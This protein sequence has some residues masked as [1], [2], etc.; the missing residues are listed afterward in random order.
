MNSEPFADAA[1][2][3]RVL[4]DN[5]AGAHRRAARSLFRSLAD[6]PLRPCRLTSS[7]SRLS[8]RAIERPSAW[9][10]PLGASFKAMM[11]FDNLDVVVLT[12]HLGGFSEQGDENVNA[13]AGVGREK[14]RSLLR[15]MFDP[16]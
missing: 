5:V 13:Q 10:V 8:A 11:R 7:R 6:N 15:Q 16:E 14:S 2:D 3:D 4:A 1:E 12:E 9:A